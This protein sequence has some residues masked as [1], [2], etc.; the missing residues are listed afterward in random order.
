MLI[1]HAF[2]NKKVLEGNTV[3]THDCYIGKL[4]KYINF[5]VNHDMNVH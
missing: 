2:R 4:T 1:Y 5:E 3:T